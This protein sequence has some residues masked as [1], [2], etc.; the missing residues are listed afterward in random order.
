MLFKEIH[1]AG[2][3]SEAID[4]A[5]RRWEKVAVKEHSLQKTSIGL[6]KIGIITAVEEAAISETESHRAG[7]QSREQL[8]KSLRQSSGTI[9][10]IEVRYHSEDPRIALREQDK[11][12]ESHFQ[13]LLQKLNRL[14]KH[15]KT[16]IW[17]YQVLSAIQTNPR[18]RAIDLSKDTGFEKEILKLNVR[19]LK[20]LGLTISHTIGYEI[21]PLGHLFLER[22]KSEDS[23]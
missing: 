23:K 19:K 18:K 1:L 2:I 12:S 7:F 10:R 21:A 9:Y 16:G 17:T 5:F 8:A 6:V 3:K 20:N 22:L 4:L 14:D 15:C 11:L 13:D